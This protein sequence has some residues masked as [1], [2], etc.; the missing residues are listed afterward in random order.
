MALRYALSAATHTVGGRLDNMLSDCLTRWHIRFLPRPISVAALLRPRNERRMPSFLELSVNHA[1][2]VTD[3]R[4][5][6]LRNGFRI[7]LVHLVFA[8]H[9]ARVSGMGLLFNC[10][11]LRLDRAFFVSN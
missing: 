3:Q 5:F 9:P 10:L 4:A 1:L 6:R 2:Q 11:R 8:L 7:L